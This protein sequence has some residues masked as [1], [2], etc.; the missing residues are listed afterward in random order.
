[1]KLKGIELLGT[2]KVEYGRDWFRVYDSND[3]VVYY[4]NSKGYWVKIEYDSNGNQVYYENSDGYWIKREYDSNNNKV[5]HKDSKGYW[6]KREYDSN[7]NVVYSENSYGTIFDKRVKNEMTLEE[8]C[9][10][11]GRDI[12]IIKKEKL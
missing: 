9:K 6:I 12:K 5:Y 7:G 10:E 2:Y 8:I 3:N 4:E 11:L 1:M